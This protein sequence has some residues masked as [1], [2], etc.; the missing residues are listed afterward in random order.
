M[1]ASAPLLG[2]D[3][4]GRFLRTRARKGHAPGYW[5]GGVP[6]GY[7][8]GKGLISRR[9]CMMITYDDEYGEVSRTT[10]RPE[11]LGVFDAAA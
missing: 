11:M 1:A 5:E 8:M 6:E 7:V 4:I 3:T 9:G 2:N 10:T